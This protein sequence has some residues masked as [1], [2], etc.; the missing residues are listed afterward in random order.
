LHLQ[1]EIKSKGAQPAQNEHSSMVAL[2]SSTSV[3]PSSTT[4]SNG[5]AVGISNFS[6]AFS[7]FFSLSLA[8]ARTMNKKGPRDFG[9]RN[10][11]GG[12]GEKKRIPCVSFPIFVFYFFFFFDQAIW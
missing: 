10:K 1:G 3:T 12:G 4:V 9:G 11:G 5:G 7:S 2:E 8:Q 6:I